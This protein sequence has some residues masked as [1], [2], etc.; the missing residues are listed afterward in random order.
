M[1]KLRLFNLGGT[2]LVNFS[3]AFF[4]LNLKE[5][6]PHPVWQSATTV[7]CTAF[8]GR[9][10]INCRLHQRV[11]ALLICDSY[12]WLCLSA[13]IALSGERQPISGR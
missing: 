11:D 13:V 9:S 4:S 2:R 5:K 1:L 7:W 8:T 6:H 3:R 10:K 12:H